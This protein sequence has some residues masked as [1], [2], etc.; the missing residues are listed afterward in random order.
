MLQETK[1]T[2]LCKNKHLIQLLNIMKARELNLET[3]QS[4]HTLRNKQF[5]C[6]LYGT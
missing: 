3:I 1:K 6:A 4:A 5:H 2:Q